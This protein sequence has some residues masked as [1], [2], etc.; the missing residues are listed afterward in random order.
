MSL[1]NISPPHV[2]LAPTLRS[3]PEGL[4][5]WLGE[6]AWGPSGGIAQLKSVITRPSRPTLWECLPYNVHMGNG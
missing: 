2:R 3:F 4:N 5:T 6:L 1:W